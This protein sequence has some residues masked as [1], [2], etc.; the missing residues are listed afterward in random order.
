MKY[1]QNH[2][3]LTDFTNLVTSFPL[4]SQ[5]LGA[6]SPPICPL[7][8]IQ[9]ERIKHHKDALFLL[10]FPHHTYWSICKVSV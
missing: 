1:P 10:L 8:Q 3:G 4:S 2:N 5:E 9:A 7:L 6:F